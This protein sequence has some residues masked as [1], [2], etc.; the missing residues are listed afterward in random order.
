MSFD[1]RRTWMGSLRTYEVTRDSFEA[2]AFKDAIRIYST[3]A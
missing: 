3:K 2:P 1:A